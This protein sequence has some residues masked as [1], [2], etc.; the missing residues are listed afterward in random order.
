MTT[1]TPSGRSASSPA[2]ARAVYF[3]ADASG[4]PAA[5]KVLLPE[6]AHDGHLADR[7]LREARTAQAVTSEGVAR[8]LAAELEGGRPWIATEFL[9]GPTLD[10]AVRGFGPL[11]DAAVR[12]LTRSLARTLQDVHATGLVHRDVKP[13]N[14]VLTSRGPSEAGPLRSAIDGTTVYLGGTSLAAVE[15]SGGRE[16][17]ALNPMRPP[18]SRG[19]AGWGP[20]TVAGGVVYALDCEALK[21]LHSDGGQAADPVMVAGVAPPWRPPVVQGNS[22][23]VVESED[24]GVTGLP[25][26]GGDQSQTY[27]LAGGE[28]RSIAADGNR[29][30]VLNRA[31][32]LALPVY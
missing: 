19:T 21:S 12:E 24:T 7:F 28:A 31:T 3:G 18:N 10:D 11:D 16:L 29:L 13:P 2:S 22:V 20:P 14:V 5:V 23:W 9:A 27:A 26:S 4:R 25:R 17:W 1:R 8:V 6:L 30:F 15:A 32:L